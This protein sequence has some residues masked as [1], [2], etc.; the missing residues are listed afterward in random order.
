MGT[1]VPDTPRP[2]AAGTRLRRRDLL[3]EA[4]AALAQRPTRT[5][6]TM[7]GTI[8]GVG[9]FVAVLGLTAT[10]T[11]QI[12]STFSAL[13][14]TEVVVDDVG[15]AD[16]DGTA[17]SFPDDADELA[18]AVSGVTAAGRTWLLPGGATQVGTSL[19]FDATTVQLQVYAATPGYLHALEPTMAS[20]ALF[21]DFER[22]Q[23]MHVAVLGAAAASRLGITSTVLDPTVVVHGT[24]YTVIGIIADVQRQ[25]GALSSVFLPDT[26]ALQAYGRPEATSPASMLVT[27]QLGA[28]DQVAE[29][30]PTALRPDRPDLLRAT[31]PPSAHPVESDVFA[32][33][34]PVFVALA[35]LTL[36]IGAVGIA[37]TTLVAVVERTGEIGLRRSLGARSRDIARQFLTE[38]I[39]VG[40]LG[41]LIGTALAVLT[42]LAVSLAESWTAI[43]DPSYTLAAPLVGALTGALA[44]VW[45]ARRAAHV[46]PIQALRR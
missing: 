2:P 22:A 34:N 23:T 31:P 20:G 11:G 28:A 29:Q 3:G 32:A 43:L 10:A 42:V 4:V 8:L 35:G 39:L 6:L 18:Q 45:P 17:S 21:T 40:T 26:T 9:A 25:A 41:G 15:T 46:P 30:L 12:T 24:P 19:R 14:A 1:T 16:V 33:L 37:N 5:V 7:L 27:T 13:R 44:G 36:L 38:A